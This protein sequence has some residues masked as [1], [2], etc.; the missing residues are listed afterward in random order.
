MSALEGVDKRPSLDTR[1]SSSRLS[2]RP[3]QRPTSSVPS[4]SSPTPYD[5]RNIDVSELLVN[6]PHEGTMKGWEAVLETIL[7]DS[8]ISIRQLRLPLHGASDL[9]IRDQSSVSSLSVMNNLMRRTGSIASKGTADSS[10]GRTPVFNTTG[11]RW[12]SKN[13]SRPKLYSSSTFG[14]SRT[15]SRT[16]LEESLW[17]PSGSSTWSKPS[18]GPTQSTMSTDSLASRSTPSEPAYKQSIGFANALS[19]A[20]IREEGSLMQEPSIDGELSLMEDE[21]L[22]LAGAPWGKEGMVHHKHHLETTDKKAKDRSWNECFAVVEKGWLR[23]F[24]FNKPSTRH[25]PSRLGLGVK[26]AGPAVVG[27][28]N[29]TENAEAV[30]A[31]MLRQT[32][33]IILPPPGYSKTRQH[34]FALTL[35]NGAIH[36]FQVGTTEILREFSQT[37]NYWSARL[38]KEPLVGGVS[39]VEYGWSDNV[40]NSA[41]VA[42]TESGRASIKESVSGS[43]TATPVNNTVYPPSSASAARTIV[44]HSPTP[45]T[46]ISLSGR[47]SLQGSLRSGRGSLDHGSSFRRGPTLPA[48]R[49]VLAE[50]TPPQQSLYPSLLSEEDQLSALRTYVDS[51]NADL[52]HHNDLRGAMGLAFSPRSSNANRA[53]MNWERKSHHLLREVVKFRTYVDNLEMAAREKARV[54]SGERGVNHGVDESEGLRGVTSTRE[55]GKHSRGV[56]GND[57]MDISH[58]DLPEETL[59]ALR[60]SKAQRLRAGTGSTV[61]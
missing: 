11:S 12:S 52:Q 46:S 29:W 48:D 54:K 21:D 20:I 22:G 47:P 1:N 45:S 61:G 31:F 58:A 3:S 60:F 16:S 10:R 33:A 35:P 34:V 18:W 24:S 27:G 28:G 42:N 5:S 51:V 9:G 15:G 57:S 17:S 56:S 30:G 19:H 36:L 53:M 26:S 25:K 59:E 44:A 32:Q 4:V 38:S 13:R 8:Y 39:N 41:L 55:G 23:L 14:S 49:L 37:V 6:A 7:K 2:I 50:W 40:I 43:R